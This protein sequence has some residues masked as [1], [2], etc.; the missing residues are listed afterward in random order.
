[1][2]T[3]KQHRIIAGAILAL[4]LGAVATVGKSLVEDRPDVAVAR[5]QLQGAWIATRVGSA[6][7]CFVEGADAGGTKIRFD[8]RNV[9]FNGLVEGKDAKGVF[10][11]DPSTKP[12]RID[13]KVDAGWLSA[14]YEV[15][16]DELKL[17]TNSLR[18]LEQLGIPNQGRAKA[19]QPSLGHY[20]YV[21]RRAAD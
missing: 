21:F 14:I 4:G 16:A 6:P 12:K 15:E 3:I 8:G 17:C 10:S 13:M 1:M 19:F 20:L 11:I 9:L 18:L 2:M 7:G 5:Q